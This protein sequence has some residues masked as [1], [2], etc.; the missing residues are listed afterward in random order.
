MPPFVDDEGK[1]QS[2]IQQGLDLF[3][4]APDAHRE[5]N[6]AESRL[7]GFAFRVIA[8]QNASYYCAR[9]SQLESAMGS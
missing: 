1:E 2:V 5:I 4:F 7:H 9:N 6:H 3:L 8:F